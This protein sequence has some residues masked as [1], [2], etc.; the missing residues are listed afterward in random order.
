MDL[1][2]VHLNGY[3]S[4][5]ARKKNRI[6]LSAFQMC[7]RKNVT[8]PDISPYDFV[9]R[10]TLKSATMVAEH[11]KNYGCKITIEESDYALMDNQEQNVI[12]FFERL[13]RPVTCPRCGSNQITTGQRGFSLVTGFIGSNKTVNRCAKCGYSWKP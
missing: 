13:N 8:Q 3:T 6:Y 11:L 5:Q 4:E 7:M 9:D 2:K 12:D 1:Y 10:V